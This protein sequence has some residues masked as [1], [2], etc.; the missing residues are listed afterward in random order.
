MA[1]LVRELLVSRARGSWD[2]PNLVCG[3]LHEVVNA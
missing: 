1:H 2:C 3:H